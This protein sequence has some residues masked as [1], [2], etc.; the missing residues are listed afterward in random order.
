MTIQ[1]ALLTF[2][3]VLLA[4][5]GLAAPDTEM[6]N[7]APERAEVK[8][9]YVRPAETP[10]PSENPFSRDKEVLGRTL[11]FDTRISGSHWIACSTCHNPAFAWGDGLPKAI[12]TG[13]KVLGR[14]SPTI[15]N[16][17]WT[18]LL[19]WD[20]RAESLEQQA[21]GPIAAPGEMNQTLGA[22]V[23]TV[24]A[25]P[26]YRPLFAKAFPGEPIG[27]DTVAKAIATFERTIVS[28]QAPFD[29]WI[30]GREDAI[31]EDAK[32]GFDLFNGKAQCSKCHTDW[33]FTDGGFHDIGLEGSD[34]GRAQ[35]L[36]LAAM[37]NAF[38]TPTLR[39]VDRRAPY[40]HDGSEATLEQVVEFYDVGGK[41][42][43]P[44]VA[45]EMKPLHLTANEKKQLVEFLKTLTSVD[46]P[47]DIPVMPK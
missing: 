25:I 42:R 46:A 44:S 16:S 35:H 8:K 17:A 41:A 47:V 24:S 22:M 21:L 38:K 7:A 27:T 26:E 31:S 4:V 29:A 30:A 11:F 1:S 2:G 36:H 23:A 9:K 32:E 18:E 40:M 39:S 34:P 5:G 15:L 33:I 13:M 10:F 20:G 19:F 37:Q 28:G 45:P 12:G 6:R 3:T 14:R 43:R